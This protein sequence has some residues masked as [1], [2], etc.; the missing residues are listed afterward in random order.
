M[1]AFR[2]R[3]RAVFIYGFAKN[4][5]ENI[6]DKELRTLRDIANAWLVADVERIESEIANGRLQEVS[7]DQ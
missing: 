5:R 1:L 7:R 3:H 4:E 2:S 6:D